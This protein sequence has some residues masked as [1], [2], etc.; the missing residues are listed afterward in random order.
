M[1]VNNSA[2]N[3]VL[4]TLQVMGAHAVI[5]PLTIYAG[6]EVSG[7]HFNPVVTACFVLI[8]KLVRALLQLL[9]QDS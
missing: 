2:G 9:K 4:Q 8:G 6:A 7:S 1:A 3:A 5:L